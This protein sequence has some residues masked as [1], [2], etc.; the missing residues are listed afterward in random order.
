M[1]KPLPLI[2]LGVVVLLILAVGGFMLRNYLATQELNTRADAYAATIRGGGY[3]VSYDAA[4]ATDDGSIAL[5]NASIAA[6]ADAAAWKLTAPRLVIAGGETGQMTLQ[7]SGDQTLQYRLAGADHTATLKSDTTRLVLQ[8]DDSGRVT[9]A[10]ADIVGL[11]LAEGDAAPITA[12][13]LRLQLTRAAGDAAVPSG[14]TLLVDVEAAKVPVWSAGPLGDTIPTFSAEMT[15]DKDLPTL[16]LASALAAWNGAGGSL[17]VTK[18]AVQWGLLSAEATGTLTLDPQGRPAGTLQARVTDFFPVIDAF[19][20]VQHYAADVLADWYA[21]LVDEA[22]GADPEEANVGD[23][24]VGIADGTMIVTHPGTDL[25][26]LTLGTV[27]SVTG[28][29]EG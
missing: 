18:L 4:A 12:K 28:Q 15:I 13:Q 22:G 3:E 17:D 8:R 24:V 27:P 6:P 9:S 21:T 23:F 10:V 25:E 7:A 5:E 2:V 11:T 1:R 29:P 26:G 20:V 19:H 16:N 14:S